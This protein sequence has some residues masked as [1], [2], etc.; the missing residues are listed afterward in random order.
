MRRQELL[1]DPSDRQ[2]LAPQRDLAR[3]GHLALHRPPGGERGQRGHDCH[4]GRRPILGDGP[5][6]HVHVD[7]LAL[8]ELGIDVERLSIGPHVGDGGLRALAHDVAEHTGKDQPL[9]AARHHRHRREEGRACRRSGASR[10]SRSAIS[11]T[12]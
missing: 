3:H 2:H 12:V 6:R 5:G 4:A 10:V 8:E 1:L 7:G 9:F 11:L